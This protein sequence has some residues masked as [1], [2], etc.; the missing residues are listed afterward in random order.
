MVAVEMPTA[1]GTNLSYEMRRE[2]MHE[3]VAR[4]DGDI[5]RIRLHC[6][7]SVSDTNE[8]SVYLPVRPSD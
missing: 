2:G 8:T 7:Q 5:L 6:L 3:R 1:P 4:E